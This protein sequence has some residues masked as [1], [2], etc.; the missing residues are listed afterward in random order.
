M[1]YYAQREDTNYNYLIQ[2]YSAE[3]LGLIGSKYWTNHPTFPLKEV[4]YMINSD[5]VGRLRENRLQLSGTVNGSGMGR[6]P[7]Y[8]YSWFGHQKGSCGRR[9]VGPDLFLLQG[10]AGVA[11]VHWNP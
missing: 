3:E 2:F 8:A 11:P 7:R 10:F 6:D 5:M 1:R 4:E 9:A